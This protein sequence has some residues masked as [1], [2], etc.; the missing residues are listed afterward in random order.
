M[1]LPTPADLLRLPATAGTALE[2]ALAL[3]PQMAILVRD[4]DLLVRE[5]RAVISDARSTQQLAHAVA[6]EAQEALTAAQRVVDR[7]VVTEAAAA[8]AVVE[9]T[10]VTRRA[11]D[12]LDRFEPAL[13]RLAP[14][15]GRVADTVTEADADAL[16]EVVQQAPGIVDRLTDEVLPVLDSL[17]TVAPDLHEVLDVSQGLEEM[18]GSV[19]GLGRVRKRVEAERRR[20]ARDD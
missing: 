5:T 14:L 12:L 10:T 17:E 16:V 13:D 1:R 3:V 2:T 8:A 9:V 4:L 20:P 19:P 15:A 7:A 18:L 6:T 11:T